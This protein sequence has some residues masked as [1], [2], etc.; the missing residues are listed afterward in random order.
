VVEIGFGTGANLEHY[1]SAVESITAIEPSEGMRDRASKNAPACRIPVELVAGTAENIPLPDHSL[2]TAVSTL[3][4][5]TVADPTRAL[6]AL[7]RVLRD[8]G[9]MILLEHGL[10]ADPKI[11]RWQRRLNP[12][13][14]IVACGCNLDR[15]IVP[16]VECSGFRFDEV[17]TFY[18]PKLPRTHGWITI[19]TAR[20]A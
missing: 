11:A 20:K 2:D 17:R 9:Q 4:L 16:L 5:C 1:P 13:Q 15:A 3:T 18:A 10:S 19:G 7:R 8:D 6:T 12:I 14:R